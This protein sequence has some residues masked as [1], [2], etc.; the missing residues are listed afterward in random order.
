MEKIL[1]ITS[2][3]G[4]AECCWV[5]AQVLKIMIEEARGKSIVCTI[6]HREKGVEN[7]TLLSATV[8][9]EGDNV[10]EFCKQWIGTI[11]WIGHSQFRK[12][13]K[14]KNWFV[15]VN[16]LDLGNEILHISDKDIS[17]QAIRSG[18]PGGQ[19]V[20][21]VSTAIRATHIP[22][23]ISV[24][25]SDSRSQLNNKKL[26]KERLINLLKLEQLNSKKAKIKE[27]WQNHNSLERGNPIKTF[28]G[29]DF[30]SRK[31]SKTYKSKRQSLKKDLRGMLGDE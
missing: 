29:S 24:L 31:V 13:H 28:T 20:N 26:A 5:V 17:Y 19:H 14:R 27:D 15:G 2:G 16:E 3:R 11:K 23:N 22:T 21:K 8:Q 1:Q 12:D 25:A 7:T 6:L 4:P 30:K 10:K 18:G 9:L